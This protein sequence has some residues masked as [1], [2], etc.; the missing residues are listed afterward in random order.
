MYKA[1][2]FINNENE[3]Q[4]AIS[5]LLG[6]RVLDIVTSELTKLDIE[7]IYLIGGNN[8]E[9]AG[10]KK[11]NNIHEV[12]REL[13]EDDKVLLL[14]P[15]Y[16]L[17]TKE[18]YEAVLNSN[19]PA[20]VVIDENDLCQIYALD[21]IH[22]NDF[23]KVKYR[24]LRIKRHA[25]MF[26]HMSQLPIFSKLLSRRINNRLVRKGVRLMDTNNT[27]IG[28]DVVIDSSTVIYPG[29]Y[30]EGRC[31][32]G[33]YNIIQSGTYIES[34]IIGDGNV[35]ESGVNISLSRLHDNSYISQNARIRERSE[36]LNDVKVGKGS[37]IISTKLGKDVYV[38][39]LSVIESTNV[40]DNAQI[41]SCVVVAADRSNEKYSTSIGSY[42]EI[43]SNSTLIAPV[44]IGDYAL[45]AAGSTIDKNIENGD[46]GIAR[47]YQT[48]K[49]GYG[50]KN[51]NRER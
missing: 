17:M 51:H 37:E 10:I 47:L 8:L 28:P 14:S 42:A 41:G 45:V 21:A 29:V 43:G 1:V 4:L 49:V 26:S 5:P 18:D 32:I 31:S 13:Y 16:P 9:V 7:D 24:V 25:K 27:Y 11:R 3:K 50:Y 22:L 15:L 23:N 12:K 39:H 33:K 36:L 6:K 46:M 38:A 20:T 2:I 40:G 48:N 34:S 35:I 44:K 30:I 19:A